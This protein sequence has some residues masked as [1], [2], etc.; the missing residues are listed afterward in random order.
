ME[1][2]IL[3]IMYD[4]DKTL[5]TED[6][7][8]FSFIPKVGST[9]AEFWGETTEIC[10]KNNIEKIL[11]YMYVMIKKAR[12]KGIKLTREFLNACGKEIQYW[13]GVIEWFKNIN[14]YGLK[15][16]VKV[17]HYLV[18]SGTLEIVEGSKIFHEFTKTYAC[19][20]VYDDKG[21][22]I[23]PKFAINYTQKTQFYFRIAKGKTDI[24]DDDGVNQKQHSLRVPL[25]N[26]VYIGDGLTDIACMTLV[27][28]NGGTSIAVY[29]QSGEQFAK[30]LKA[31]GRVNYAVKADYREGSAIDEAVK[32]VID[33]IEI[34]HHR[35]RLGEN[36]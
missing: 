4:F 28:K 30:Q 6:M 16:G 31:D 22:A 11:S 25:S 9:P 26:I 15:H 21:E 8:N 1:Q 17:E 18:S 12:E 19:E 36:N 10:K 14:E 3:A 5:S 35:S 13:P 2:E 29:N 27:K 33:Q 20:F 7:Q 23:W 34:N 32:I 24:N